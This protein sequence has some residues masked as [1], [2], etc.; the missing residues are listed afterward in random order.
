MTAT[1]DVT[2]DSVYFRLHRSS[3]IPD[4]ADIFVHVYEANGG[5][6]PDSGTLLGIYE[7]EVRVD[8]RPNC[9]ERETKL[10]SQLSTPHLLIDFLPSKHSLPLSV[11]AQNEASIPYF[12]PMWVALS[13]T[14]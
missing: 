1:V 14:L 12:E 6:N 3:H 8:N 4:P 10:E 13:S 5:F 7:V 2:I 9:V 11:T